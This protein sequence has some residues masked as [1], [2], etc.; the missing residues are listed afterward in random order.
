MPLSS[1][2][3]HAGHFATL[4]SLCVRDSGV[5]LRALGFVSAL[6]VTHVHVIAS[7]LSFIIHGVGYP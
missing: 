4:V 1:V 2:I 6:L 7:G 5:I 3:V